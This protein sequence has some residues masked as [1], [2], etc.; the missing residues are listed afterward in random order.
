MADVRTLSN[1]APMKQKSPNE[2]SHTAFV[3]RTLGD[4]AKA[5]YICDM[6]T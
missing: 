4:Y 5:N 2:R 3:I 1:N 6:S